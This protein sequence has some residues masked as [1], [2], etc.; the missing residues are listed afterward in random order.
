MTGGSSDSGRVDRRLAELGLHLPPP[1]RPR[2]AYAGVVVHAGI[3]H[4]SG[5]VSRLGDEVIAGPMQDGFPPVLAARAAQACVLNALS[6]LKAGLGGLDAVDRI[7]HLR[8]FVNAVPDFDGHSRLL[9]QV[10]QRLQ[11]IFGERGRHARS[12]VG[13]SSLPGGG[14]LEIELTVALAP[15]FAPDFA[16][17]DRSLGG[18]GG[19]AGE[20]AGEGPGSG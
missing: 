13:A 7:L 3:A 5:Q 1:P 11:D 14:L 15:D 18:A 16:R 9:D 2:G 20:S 8:G 10:S 19:G 17:I 6:T 12:A 4:V